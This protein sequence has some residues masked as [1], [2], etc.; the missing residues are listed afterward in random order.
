MAL[1]NKLGLT[2]IRVID[3]KGNDAHGQPWGLLRVGDIETQE[4]NSFLST[5]KANLGCEGLRYVN[6]GRKVHRVAVGGGAC[7]SEMRQ[8]IDAGC[9]TFVTADA[10]YNHFWDAQGQA[11]NLIDAGHFY[12]EN[13]VCEYLVQKLSRAFPQ[14]EVKLSAK[15]TDCAKFF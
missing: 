2:D 3:P 14:L 12:T 5:V 6:G 11:L 4:L 7:A 8:V 1:E 10:K 9:D 15:H 13:P